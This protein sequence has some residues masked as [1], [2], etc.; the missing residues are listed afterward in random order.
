M[1]GNIL[2]RIFYFDL[3]CYFLFSASSYSHRQYKQ[4]EGYEL[5]VIK[6]LGPLLPQLADFYLFERFDGNKEAALKF[7]ERR[8]RSNSQCVVSIFAEQIVGASWLCKLPN[9]SAPGFASCIANETGNYLCFDSYV[10]R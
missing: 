3:D 1:I 9:E 7:V 4:N 8:I 2:K 10:N 6:D 5:V